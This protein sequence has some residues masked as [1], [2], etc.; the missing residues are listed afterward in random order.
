M[1]DEVGCGSVIVA[2]ALVAFAASASDAPASVRIA[3]LIG[4]AVV[5]LAALIAAAI[6]DRD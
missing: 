3:A 2:L 1:W 5:M 6:S 4:G